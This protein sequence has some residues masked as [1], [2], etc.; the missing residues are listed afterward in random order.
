MRNL[1]KS[2][3]QNKEKVF[4]LLITTNKNRENAWPYGNKWLPLSPSYS[5]YG[6]T[7]LLMD[8]LHIVAVI[9]LVIIGIVIYRNKLKE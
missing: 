3:A 4:F 9:A 6:K 5:F 2:I 7:L 8:W 1:S